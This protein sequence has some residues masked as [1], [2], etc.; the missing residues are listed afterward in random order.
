VARRSEVPT[1]TIS[2]ASVARLFEV[3]LESLGLTIQKYRVLAYLDQAPATPS[4]LAYRLTVQAPTVTRLVA[5]LAERG[6]ISREVDGSDRRRNVLQVTSAGRRAIAQASTASE[7]SL[8]RIL[9]PL[10]PRDRAAVDRGLRLLGGAMLEYWRLT[11][12]G[13]SGR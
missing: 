5:G 1:A 2:I 8:D 12:P 9:A 7:A 10:S 11:H 13:A 6:Y 4:E 3:T